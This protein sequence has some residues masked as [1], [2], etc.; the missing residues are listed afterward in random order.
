[1]I[2]SRAHNKI[3]LKAETRPIKGRRMIG[4][5]LCEPVLRSPFQ[6]YGVSGSVSTEAIAL[7]NVPSCFNTCSN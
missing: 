1:M 2:F 3:C 7:R 4:Q 5:A 6:R